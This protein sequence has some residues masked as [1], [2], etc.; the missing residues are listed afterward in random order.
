MKDFLYVS[1]YQ[2]KRAKYQ[3]QKPEPVQ[4]LVLG[5]TGKGLAS[6]QFPDGKIS[7]VSKNTLQEQFDLG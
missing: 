7:H 1:L 6:V 2:A 4:V 5:E 3:R